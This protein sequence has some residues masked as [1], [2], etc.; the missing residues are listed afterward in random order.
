[1]FSIKEVRDNKKKKS[2][3]EKI[4]FALPEWFDEAGRKEYPN[5]LDDKIF[6]S[7]YDK[8]KAVGLIALKRINDYT[9]E[10]YVLG[11]LKEYHG[12]SVGKTL[13][14]KAVEF[15][16]EKSYKLLMVKTLGES[17]NYEYY[18]RTRNFYYRVGF[19]PLE[20]FKEIWDEN[21][22]CLIMVKPLDEN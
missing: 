1:M 21:N 18:D 17:A 16:I 19:Y 20:E 14:N 22:P 13:L 11:V 9:I 8:E 3:T 5:N 4:I 12:N 2:I 10:I 7:V 15:A 6:F